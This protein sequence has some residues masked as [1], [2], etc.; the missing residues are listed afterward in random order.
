ME[1]S[2]WSV[3]LNNRVASGNAVSKEYELSNDLSV[4]PRYRKAYAG[5]YVGGRIL[6]LYFDCLI[7]ISNADLNRS[8]FF[9]VVLRGIG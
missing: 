6:F 9:F 4:Y 8:H 1:D 2:H 3:V 7:K 5:I